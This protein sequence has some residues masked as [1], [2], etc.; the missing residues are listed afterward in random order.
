MFVVIWVADLCTVETGNDAF[1][2]KT[3]ELHHFES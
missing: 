2:E 3:G 1:Y